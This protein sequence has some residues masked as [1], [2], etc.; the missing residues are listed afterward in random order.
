MH[1]ILLDYI[2]K[3]ST[4]ILSTTL[5][6]LTFNQLRHAWN[7]GLKTYFVFML[8]FP[9]KVDTISFFGGSRRVSDFLRNMLSNILYS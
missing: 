7:I 6:P 4:K 9:L 1:A 3:G 5:E 2:L 8:S